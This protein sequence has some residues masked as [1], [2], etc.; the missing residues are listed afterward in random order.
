MMLDAQEYFAAGA[1]GGGNHEVEGAADR[2]FGGVF[3]G[4]DGIIGL[5]GF[6]QAE[7]WP[8]CFTAAC[9]VKVASGPR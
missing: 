5:A 6:H 9:W 4:G 7:A 3:H 2:A 8:K 1:Q